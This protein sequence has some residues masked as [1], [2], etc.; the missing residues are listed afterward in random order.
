MRNSV[1]IC[2][3]LAGALA[4]PAGLAA[5]EKPAVVKAPAK[6]AKAPIKTMMSAS[7]P[8]TVVPSAPIGLIGPQAVILRAMTPDEA[9][10]NALWTI[11]AGLNVAALQCQFSPFLGTVKTYNDLLKHHSAE[12]SKAQTVLMAHF[13]RYDGARAAN[14]FDQYATRTYNSFSTLDAQ[15][16]FC[17]SASMLGHAALMIGKGEFG[18]FALTRGPELRA[19]LV[20][21][22]KP[23]IDV[24]ATALPALD[25]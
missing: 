6:K 17:E 11:R 1:L 7:P 3:I 4:L 18:R 22:P 20:P 16:A 24:A 13:K 23:V 19:A 8:L 21:S 10:A 15:Y 25:G 14:S 9:Q 5:A 12:F 2:T